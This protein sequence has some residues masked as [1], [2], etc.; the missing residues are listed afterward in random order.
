MT[1]P[2]VGTFFAGFSPPFNYISELWMLFFGRHI[3]I[4]ESSLNYVQ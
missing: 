2:T 3:V 1:E 4:S